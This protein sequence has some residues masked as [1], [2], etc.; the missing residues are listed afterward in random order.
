MRIVSKCRFR[1]SYSEVR[2][3]N[4]RFLMSFKVMTVLL[5]VKSMFCDEKMETCSLLEVTLFRRVKKKNELFIF[6]RKWFKKICSFFFLN[7]LLLWSMGDN[8]EFK[9]SLNFLKGQSCMPNSLFLI[10]IFIILLDHCKKKKN[11]P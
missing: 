9:H 11:K 6:P 10:C 8:Q 1:F 7:F 2:P 3:E 4:L 5:S